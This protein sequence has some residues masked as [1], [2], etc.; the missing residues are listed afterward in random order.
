MSTVMK[1]LL[2][3]VLAKVISR[4]LFISLSRSAILLPVDSLEP[5]LKLS[6][7]QLVFFFLLRQL[8]MMQIFLHIIV[9]PAGTNLFRNLYPISCTSLTSLKTTQ[10]FSCSE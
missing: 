9:L 2:S 3:L 1:S 6:E 5:A 7:L 10:T 4:K 8:P